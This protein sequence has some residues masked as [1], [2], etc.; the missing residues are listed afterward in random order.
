MVVTFIIVVVDFL[1]II[2]SYLLLQKKKKYKIWYF[3]L[4]KN[5]TRSMVWNVKGGGTKGSYSY[6]KT[7]IV[8]S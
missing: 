2:P 7:L 4:L 8:G 6:S 3:S 1:T 5:V